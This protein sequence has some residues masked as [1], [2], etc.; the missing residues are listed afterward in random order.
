MTAKLID[1]KALA[2]SIK[3]KIREKVSRYSAQ[4]YRPPGLAVVLVGED[5]ASKVYVRNKRRFCEEVGIQSFSHDLAT[6]TREEELL[7]LIEELNQSEQVD[8]ILVQLPLPDH[9]DSNKVIESIHNSKDVDGYSAYNMG[10]LALRQPNLN[11]CTPRGVMLLLDHIG[12]QYKGKEAVVVGASNHVGRPMCL[13]LLLAGATV[14]VT[15]RF[16]QDLHQH[17]SRADILV[18]AAG[19]KGLVPGEWIKDGAIVVDIGI[20]RLPDGRLTGDV[21]FESA[22]KKASWITPVPGGVGPMTVAVLMDNTIKTYEA[23]LGMD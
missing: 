4:G 3:D 5:P 12:T 2:S 10:R 18:V 14:T 19:K 8:G 7:K 20:H 6:E 17:V 21:D 22:A 13:E 1:G 23:H 9:M 15:H 11:S 16:T